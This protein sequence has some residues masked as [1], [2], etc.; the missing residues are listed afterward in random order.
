MRQQATDALSDRFFLT[1]WSWGGVT[2]D[3]MMSWHLQDPLP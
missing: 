2:Q 3:D 1:G